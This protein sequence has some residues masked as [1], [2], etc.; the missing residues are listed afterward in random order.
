MVYIPLSKC[1]HLTS[2]LTIE[3]HNLW[4]VFALFLP[5]EIWFMDNDSQISF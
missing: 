3:E 2:C 1:F 4:C 5:K